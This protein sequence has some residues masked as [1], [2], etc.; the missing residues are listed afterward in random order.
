MTRFIADLRLEGQFSN[1]CILC[2][3]FELI[4][5]HLYFFLL[6]SLYLLDSA[7]NGDIAAILGCDLRRV[8]V[9]AWSVLI[10]R[11]LSQLIFH[12]YFVPVQFLPACVLEQT[13]DNSVE[14]NFGAVGKSRLFY[15]PLKV[16]LPE[17]VVNRRRY[18][19][20]IHPRHDVIEVRPHLRVVIH[21]DGLFEEV[22]RAG[23]C[24]RTRSA[25]IELSQ[26]FL[27]MELGDF[28]RPLRRR[29]VIYS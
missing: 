3:L 25:I 14:L 4:F 1:Y 18:R 22:A 16:R 21:A 19:A 6:F 24:I 29:L 27:L 12:L 8:V 5:H 10:L 23:G 11:H 20:L 28:R 26:L 7:V 13:I 2:L 15:A 9:D 17:V